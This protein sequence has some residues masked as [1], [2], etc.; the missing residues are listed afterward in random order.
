MSAC[1]SPLVSVLLPVFNGA[2]T[3]P[4]ALES[5]LGQTFHDWELVVVDDGSTDATASV[6]EAATRGDARVR[7]LRQE[8]GGIVR[9]L[10]RA[11]AAARGRF[12]ARMDADDVCHPERFGEQAGWL[13]RHPAT[14]LVSCLISHGGDPVRQAGFARHVAW[15]N[16]LVT[17]DDIRRNRFVDAPVAHPSVMFRRECVEAHGGYREGPFPEDYELWLRWL[18][19]GVRFEKVPRELLVWNDAAGRL[20]RHDPRYSV[21]A[22]QEARAVYLVRE[23]ERCSRGR[24][25][26][27]WGAGRVTRRRLER[28]VAA[29]LR[30]T[31]FIDVDSKKWGRHRDGRWVVGPHAVPSPRDAVVVAQVGKIGAWEVIRGHLGRAGYCEA[32]DFWMAA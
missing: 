24:A 22:F 21:E 19:A 29:G 10:N 13:E 31:G 12:L 32:E 4:A 7:W 17:H 23:V 3:L 8:H 5:V 11:T 2:R 14:G 15:L 1:G 20:S 6:L 18:E 27:V 28:L 30:V 16:G 26:W 25:V 9:A